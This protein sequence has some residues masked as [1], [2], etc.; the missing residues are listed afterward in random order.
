M[1]FPFKGDRP[2]LY[3][4]KYILLDVCIQG[5][6]LEDGYEVIDELPRSHLSQEVV[7]AVLDA[8]IRQ[9]HVLVSLTRLRG[10][11][12]EVSQPRGQEAGRSGSCGSGGA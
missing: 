1:R 7:S 2:V 11:R 3:V 4:A 9:L 6:D 12:R 10:T 8:Y 5:W